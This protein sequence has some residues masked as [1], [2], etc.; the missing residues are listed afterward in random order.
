MSDTP[1]V[2]ATGA[3]RSRLRRIAFWCAG[4]VAVLATLTVGTYFL[5]SSAGFEDWIRGKVVAKLEAATGGRIE[6]GSFHW[7]LLDLDAEAGG[8]VI[9]GREAAGEAPLARVEKMHA[10]IS[11]LQ[12]LSPK[13]QLRDLEIVRPS[14]HLIVY[15]DGSTN[16]PQRRATTKQGKPVLDT[17]FDLKAG[18]VAVEQ[19]ELDYDSRASEFD[20]QHRKLPL[21]FAAH[22][23]ST[24]V[25]Y[26]PAAGQTPESYHVEAGARDLR[27]ARGGGIPPVEGYFQATADLMRN[28]VILRSLRISARG[29]GVAE[30]TLTLSG[31]VVDFQRPR[32]KLRAQ[33]ELDMRLVEPISGYQNVPTGVTRLDLAGEGRDGQF[34]LDGPIH[35]DNGAYVDSDVDA[36]GITLDARVHADGEQLL[37]GSTVVRLRQGGQLEGTILLTHWLNSVPGEPQMGPAPPVKP[38]RR[39]TLGRK[40]KEAVPDAATVHAAADGAAPVNGK[41]TAQLRNV[42][43]DA[44]MDIVA[45]GPFERLGLATLLNGPATA[46][47]S[48]GDTRT[49]EVDAKLALS[50]THGLAG[51]TPAS[52]VLDATYR[53]RDG[54]VDLRALEINMPSSRLEAHG[55]LGAY[56]TSSPSEIA[57]DLRSQNLAEFDPVLRDLGLKHGGKSGVAAIPVSLGGEVEFR[58]T[59]AGSLSDPHLSGNLTANNLAVELPAQDAH[60]PTRQL[61]VDTLDAAGSYSATRIALDRADLTEHGATIH[62]A[63][64]LTAAG[65]TT[66][67][68]GVP[69][70]DSNSLLHAHATANKTSAAELLSA[71]SVTAPV[72]GAVSAQ[73]QADGPLHSLDGSGWI[74]LDNGVVYDE[75]IGRIRAQ[76][77]IAGRVVQLSSVTVNDDAG[78]L[79]ATGSYD[80]TARQF[81]VSAHGTGIDIGR[82]RRLQK[83]GTPINGKAGFTLTGGGTLDDPRLQAKGTLTGLTLGNEPVGSVQVT[84][85]TANRTVFYDVATQF[86]SAS[87]AAHGQT[88]FHDDLATEAHVTFS[89]FNIAGLLK[90]AKIPGLTGESALAGTITVQGPL[91]RV[92]ALR[93][94]AKVNDL[95]V[96][97]AGVH[98]RSE[99]PV[100]A[101]LANG[102][103]AMDPLHVTGEATDVHAQGGLEL[104]GNRRLDMAAS[105]SINLKLAETLDPD[106]T[107]S[108]T[109]TFEVE[110]HGPLSNPG[111]RG[112]IELQNASLALQDLP[113]SLS[114]LKGTLE[115]NQNR[116]EVRSLTAV[117][118]GG[119][120]SVSGYLAYQHGIFADLSMTGK[121]VRIRYPDGV[122]SLADANLKLQG[123]QS[124][125][126]LSGGIMIT[127]F[128][129]SPELDIAGLATRA[130][131][132]QTVTSP[133][134]PSN[135]VR[136]DV[137]IQS[138]PQLNFQ[139]AYAKLAGDVDLRLRGTLATPSLLGRI[140]ITEGSATLAGTRYD[141][142]RGDITFNNPV[143]IEPSI[144]LNATARVDDYDI[145][146]GLHGTL[147]KPNISYRSDPPLPETDVVALLALGRTQSGQQMYGQQQVQ[148]ANSQATDVLLGGAL[149]ATVSS[150]VQ[151]L[152]GAGSV[153]VDPT[154]LGALGN[155]TTRITVEEQVG[156]NLKLTYATDVNATSQQ[157]LQAEIAI[158]RHVSLL[159]TRDES[160]VFSMVVKATRRYR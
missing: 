62:A 80:L 113:N 159:V 51:E 87:L 13:I 68:L 49:L 60:G 93:G 33:G 110:A 99:G 53:Q 94:E 30:R 2:P 17:V 45:E 82:I 156:R 145:T 127:R 76:G 42:P 130:T 100:H 50:P 108:G 118:G 107:A 14:V 138:S 31:S 81:Q 22:D 57:V 40:T 3:R 15:A 102:R 97:L 74:E 160:G 24:V 72:T 154:Y 28:A 105:G 158:N 16:Q 86:E 121:S 77:K 12:L 44:V 67:R 20:S 35:V 59:W 120:L 34:R 85:H 131:K 157:L 147:D 71:L 56:P 41:V 123:S 52:G 144:D 6:L 128:T 78:K 83:A 54:A 37:I 27:L 63:G 139:N 117:T 75:P 104:K 89:K 98:L 125:L 48:N 140:S 73:L 66:Q 32:W 141:L 150:R 36:R 109:T 101:V 92:D 148:G 136:L 90:L 114:Q 1:Q 142:Q 47:W 129:V 155:S 26:V 8:L 55:H 88:A 4:T 39:W 126:L 29:K 79:T 151:K 132:V 152:F 19:G 106:L 115:F 64:S 10:R 116:L 122:S 153:K 11:I 7:H 61:H 70:F 43:I 143:R 137:H 21:D 119:Q 133:N 95:A 103:I 134:A 124:N 65:T 58:G 38:K 25:S 111:M 5:A 18:R 112:R 69:Q 96:T 84:A 146:L 91:K 23:V 149:N 9:H 135:H 46:T